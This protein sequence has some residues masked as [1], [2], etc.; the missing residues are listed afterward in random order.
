M[1]DDGI[2][3]ELWSFPCQ[4]KFKVMALNRP[5]IDIDIISAI[6]EVIPGDYY[7]ELKPSA[8]GK[9]VSLTVALHLENKE[10]VEAVYRRVRLVDDV[11]LCL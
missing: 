9:F 3:P 8:K 6:Q 10:Q 4:I 5:S 7:P 2:N 1:S 11:K